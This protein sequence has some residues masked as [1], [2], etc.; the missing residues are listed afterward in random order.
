M[1][2]NQENRELLI[3]GVDSMRA[4]NNL[5]L[6]EITYSKDELVDLNTITIKKDLDKTERIMSFIKEIKNPYL[7]RIGDVV[8]KVG[9]NN[10]GHSFQEG[11]E[12]IVK[13]NLKKYA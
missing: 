5:S 3:H 8:V 1:N 9:F 11:F 10:S 2:I 12:D 6:S 13:S 7:F 4:Y